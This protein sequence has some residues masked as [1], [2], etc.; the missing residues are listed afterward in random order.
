MKALLVLVT[1]VLLPACGGSTSPPG[2]GTGTAYFKIDQVS[3]VYSGTKSVTFYIDNVEAGTELL[4][5]GATSIGYLTKATSAYTQ[6]GHPVVQARLANYTA[7]GGALWTLRANIN[8][9]ANGSVTY[10]FTC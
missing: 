7:T 4:L 3:C 5:T 6:P 8:V 2:A 10:A 1:F 9:P